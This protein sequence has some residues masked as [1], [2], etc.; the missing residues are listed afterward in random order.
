MHTI[1]VTDPGS[2]A[3]TADRVGFESFD[4]AAV[5]GVREQLGKQRRVGVDSEDGGVAEIG[6]GEGLGVRPAAEV[7]RAAAVPVVRGEERGEEFALAG[8]RAFDVTAQHPRVV[9]GHGDLRWVGAP[10]RARA[11]GAR[12][13]RAAAE[14]G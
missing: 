9:P 12:P 8:G 11:R 1:A 7:D 13:A 6:E 10:S 2:R 4:G 14:A 5:A 3:S